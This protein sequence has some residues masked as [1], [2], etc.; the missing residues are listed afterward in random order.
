MNEKMIE[1]KES[2]EYL[3]ETA[4]NGLEHTRKAADLIKNESVKKALLDVCINFEKTFDPLEKNIDKRTESLSKMEN[5]AKKRKERMSNS[6]SRLKEKMENLKNLH[7][8]LQEK[9]KA[10][11]KPE[12]KSPKKSKPS[13]D[14]VQNPELLSAQ[15]LLEQIGQKIISASAKPRTTGNIWENWKQDHP[16][17][18]P[19]SNQ[20]DKDKKS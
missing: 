15:Q 14:P 1:I 20:N 18:P 12:M 8:M 3:I 9:M 10:I 6:N 7:K 16:E 5:E 17:S 13:T 4:K 11:P 19:S 2:S